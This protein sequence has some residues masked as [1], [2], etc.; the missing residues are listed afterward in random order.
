MTAFGAA[1]GLFQT[2]AYY[3]AAGSTAAQRAAF[4]HEMEVLG[5]SLR[6]LLPIPVRVDTV[7]GYLQWRVYGALPIL[8]VFWAL[9]SATGATRGDEEHGLVEQWLSAGVGKARYTA[10]RFLAF[11]VA[12]LVAVAATST[13][14]A[15][16]AATGG[17]PLDAASVF[18]MSAAVL[19]VTAVC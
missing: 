9:M 14:I 5:L 1:Y 2:A 12:S 19:A 6:Y 10:L 11:L 13:A 7:P 16:V 17:S 8:F 4:G 15:L 3:S 18:E